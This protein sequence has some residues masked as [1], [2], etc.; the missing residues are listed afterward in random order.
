RAGLA[1]ILRD[2][3]KKRLRLVMRDIEF[4]PDTAAELQS[5][6]QRRCCAHHFNGVLEENSRLFFLGGRSINLGAGFPVG[7]QTVQTDTARKRRLTV[8]FA[9][10]DVGA[11]KAARTVGPFPAEERPKLE[12]LRCMQ[13]EWLAFELAF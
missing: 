7:N 10:F 8:A 11:T 5:F 13:L 2:R 12:S 1:G 6:D 3:T 4:A 9:L